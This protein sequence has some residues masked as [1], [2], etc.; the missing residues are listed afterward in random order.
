MPRI[1]SISVSAVRVPLDRV[2]S[3]STRTVKSRDYC[4]VKMRS[5]DGVEG[6]GFC[7]VGTAGASIAKLAIQELLAPVVLGQESDRVEG[8]WEEMYR[9]ALLHGR[10]GTVMRALSV[11]D[12]ALWD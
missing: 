2:T 7:Y 1:S 3:F 8:L 6:I 11:L 4:L 12:I 10:V 5:A 9:E